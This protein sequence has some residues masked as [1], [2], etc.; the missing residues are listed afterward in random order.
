VKAVKKSRKLQEKNNLRYWDIKKYIRVIKIIARLRIS[1]SIQIFVQLLWG[2][3]I[4]NKSIMMLIKKVKVILLKYKI[5]KELTTT[6]RILVTIM[7]RSLKKNMVHSTR[8]L[9]DLVLM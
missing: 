3:L 5:R 6:M 9:Q 1:L 8:M 4:S 7:N 2:L